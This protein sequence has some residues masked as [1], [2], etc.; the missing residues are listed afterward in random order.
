MR[1]LN[2][3]HMRSFSFTSFLFIIQNNECS[4]LYFFVAISHFEMDWLSA[5]ICF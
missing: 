4:F 1:A 3:Y 2:L 5:T